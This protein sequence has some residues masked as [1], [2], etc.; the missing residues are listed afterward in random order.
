MLRGP[1]R[2]FFPVANHEM[3]K[4]ATCMFTTTQD[5]HFIVDLHPKHS[6]VLCNLICLLVMITTLHMTYTWHQVCSLQAGALLLRLVLSS[7]CLLI[8][9]MQ[10]PQHAAAPTCSCPN[11]Q[12]PQTIP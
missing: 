9:N 8:P 1:L 11:M 4:A 12:L 6:Q 2:K 5:R 3:T 7:C 10:L